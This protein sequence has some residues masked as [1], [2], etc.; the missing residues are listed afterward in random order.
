MNIAVCVCNSYVFKEVNMV[1]G[2][3]DILKY[4]LRGK[5][6]CLV[7]CLLSEDMC[8]AVRTNGK[9]C[10]HCIVGTIPNNNR[11]LMSIN[12]SF[13]VYTCYSD[14]YCNTEKSLCKYISYTFI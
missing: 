6:K 10:E 2:C 9:E 5:V 1:S 12:S 3:S 8:N 7:N 14:S 4:H 11:S 13:K